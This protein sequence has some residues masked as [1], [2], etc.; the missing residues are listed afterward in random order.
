ME[1]LIFDFDNKDV[2]KSIQCP[3]LLLFAEYDINVDPQENIQHL[4]DIFLGKDDLFL[5]RKKVPFQGHPD[6]VDEFA[7]V[8]RD[9]NASLARYEQIKKHAVLPLMLSIEG[10]HLT[11]TLKV[12]RRVVEKDY[13]DLIES[14]YE[15]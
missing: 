1:S 7:K 13:A 3:V 15:T 4:N 11:P 8:I 9:T 12:K 6:L 10:G 14:L 2:L 5:L